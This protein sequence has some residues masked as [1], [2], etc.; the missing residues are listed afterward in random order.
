MAND[1][2]S[3]VE[4]SVV[5]QIEAATD[6]IF[7]KIDGVTSRP[8]FACI[9]GSGL[10]DLA[11]R[12]QQRVVIPYEE[13]PHFP[14]ST[15]AGHA[16]QLVIGTLGGISVVMMQG[17]FHLYEGYTMQAVTL[18]V[19]VMNRLG[20]K[21][22]LVTN[23][24]GGMNPT[25][26]AGDLML[27]S[28]HLNMTG[29]NPLI[30]PHDERLGL[31][32]PDMS[33]AYDRDYRSLLRRV[34]ATCFAGETI[35]LREGVYAGISGPSYMTPSELMMLARCGGDAIGMSTVAEVIAARHA[36]M[37]VIGISC[38]TDMAIGEHLEPLTHEQVVATANRTKPLFIK[39][40]M[41]FF[42]QLPD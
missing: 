14:T 17:R 20:A 16:G 26:R 41:Q 37:R 31:R 36:G 2:Q 3:Y 30:G 13:I 23:A 18:P 24:A 21:Q 29:D 25:F 10:G 33:N 12:V 22:L 9:L 6:Y 34:A 4:K 19:Y 27:I 42:E 5:E 39:F 40:I 15:V 38:I 1:Q 11:E 7:S 35:V 32:F 8:Q 28:D